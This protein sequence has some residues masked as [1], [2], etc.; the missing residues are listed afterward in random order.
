MAR[1]IAEDLEMNY[2][3]HRTAVAPSLRF[4]ANDSSRPPLLMLHGVVR[5]ALDFETI[6]DLL[7]PRWRVV[8]LDQRGHGDSE[9]ARD[10]EYSNHTMSLDAEA[11]V[12]A[13]GLHRPVLIQSAGLVSQIRVQTVVDT[14]VAICLGIIQLRALSCLAIH[15]GM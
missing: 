12:A 5:G 9:W 8:A 6:F 4:L 1:R 15:K 14:V 11:F 7:E 13:L 10:L 2:T 3:F